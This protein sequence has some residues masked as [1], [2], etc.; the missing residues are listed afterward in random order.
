VLPMSK[1]LNKSFAKP[2]IH[3]PRFY[4]ARSVIY[5]AFMIVDN[6]SRAPA[7]KFPPSVNNRTLDAG[8]LVDVAASLFIIQT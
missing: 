5:S 1:K 7:G 2:M 4:P 3:G 8:D 6:G